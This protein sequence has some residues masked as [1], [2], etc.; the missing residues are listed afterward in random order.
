[1]ANGKVE[2]L[3]YIE[4]MKA[5]GCWYNR[6]V[7]LSMESVQCILSSVPDDEGRAILAD[8]VKQNLGQKLRESQEE[9]KL[10]LAYAGDEF[11]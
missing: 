4:F 10:A 2:A 8:P 1:M 9:T 5:F 6:T 3:D 7:Q 11:G